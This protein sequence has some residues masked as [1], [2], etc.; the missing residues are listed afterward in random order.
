MRRGKRIFAA[1]LSK[2]VVP[3]PRSDRGPDAVDGGNRRNANLWQGTKKAGPRLRP[4]GEYGTQ[5]QNY[6]WSLNV[7]GRV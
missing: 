4:G 6:C 7:I 2:P 1:D 3:R 5:K